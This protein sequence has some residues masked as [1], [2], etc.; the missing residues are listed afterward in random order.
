M[1]AAHLIY[2]PGTILIGMV[3]G[4]IMGQKAALAQVART[5]ARRKE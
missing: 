4:Y 5:K 2:I 3:V 1:S